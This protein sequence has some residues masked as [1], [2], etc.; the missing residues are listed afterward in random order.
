MCYYLWVYIKKKQTSY[1]KNSFL[2]N[3]KNFILSTIDKIF[4]F[5]SKENDIYIEDTTFRKKDYLNMNLIEY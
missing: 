1:K 3:N 2:K 4:L 5:L